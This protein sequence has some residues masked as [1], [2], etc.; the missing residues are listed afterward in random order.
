MREYVNRWIVILNDPAE[1]RKDFASV[2]GKG[3]FG[4]SDYEKFLAAIGE[5]LG[6]QF[7]PIPFDNKLYDV[8]FFD[9]EKEIFTTSDNKQIS[10]HWLSQGQ[11][12]IVTLNASL[13][14]LDPTKKGVVLIDEI[15]DLDPE[16]LQTVKD[17]LKEK[18]REGSVLLALLV[19]PPRE[20]SSKMIEIT[21]WS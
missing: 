20:S 14:K 10:L 13:K 2:K 17:T 19:R 11:N 15:A 1:R 18:F 21:G 9:I 6:D 4:L 16:K 8:R 3:V 5:Y 7:E 12:K